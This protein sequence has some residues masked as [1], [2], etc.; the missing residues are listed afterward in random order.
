MPKSSFF[1]QSGVSPT[2]SVSIQSSIDAAQ[3]FANQAQ[4]SVTSL[5]NV[6]LLKA[7]NLSGVAS[8]PSARTNLGLGTAA[9]TNSSD[10][11]SATSN[12]DGGQF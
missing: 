11:L 4:N 1:T 2:A 8:V 7:N 9:T 10:Y 12:I 5:T 6:A 3:S